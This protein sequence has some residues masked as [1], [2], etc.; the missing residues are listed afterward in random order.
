M[1]HSK[2]IKQVSFTADELNEMLAANLPETFNLPVP[3]CRGWLVVE[4][5]NLSM[6][7]NDNL[8]D[9]ALFCSMKIES[10]ATPIYRA[11]LL[12]N[13][14]GTPSYDPETSMVRMQNIEVVGVHLVKDEYSLI[15]DTK[16]LINQLIPSPVTSLVANTLKT[17]LQLFSAG[18]Y[19]EVSD[20]LSLYLLGSKQKIVDYHRPEVEKI[21]T[22]MAESGDLEYEMD[23]DILEEH[24]FAD[25]G[26]EVEV[27]NGELVFIFHR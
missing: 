8:I 20:Y 14:A 3:G 22:E 13:V 10:M 16:S 15:K 18:A 27:Q 5:A 26:K 1:I 7:L 4:S 11:H 17:T 23:R 9:V 19:Q 6:P 24:L 25:L 12:I 2:R 21:I